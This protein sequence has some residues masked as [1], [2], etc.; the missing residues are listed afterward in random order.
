MAKLKIWYRGD[1]STAQTYTK[2][3]FENDFNYAIWCT[4]NEL[5][6]VLDDLILYNHY[7]AIIGAGIFESEIIE[8]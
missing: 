1:K 3:E 5:G 4:Q 8:Y 7:M 6:V 2:D